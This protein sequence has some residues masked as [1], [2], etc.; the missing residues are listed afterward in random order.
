MISYRK[1]QEDFATFEHAM[2]NN[3]TSLAIEVLNTSK[4]INQ[5][6]INSDYTALVVASSLH[7]NIE[8]VKLILDHPEFD[9]GQKYQLC[10]SIK[11]VVNQY[12]VA[13]DSTLKETYRK[14]LLTLLS[15]KSF[16]SEL[17][18]KK[19]DLSLQY[20]GDVLRDVDD[21]VISLINYMAS[22]QSFSIRVKYHVSQ[23][24]EIRYKHNMAN[25]F[26]KLN[27][28]E[29]AMK[30]DYLAIIA[31]IKILNFARDERIFEFKRALP[32]GAPPQTFESVSYWIE[33]LQNIINYF[34]TGH[35][36]GMLYEITAKD[37][38]NAAMALGRAYLL[39]AI[40]ADKNDY[41]DYFNKAKQILD[42]HNIE[43]EANKRQFLAIFTSVTPIKDLSTNVNFV[44]SIDI[45]IAFAPA[46]QS[47]SKEAYMLLKWFYRST[48]HLSIGLVCHYLVEVCQLPSLTKKAVEDL[49]KHNVEVIAL[50][51]M[52]GL[53]LAADLA[54][55]TTLFEEIAETYKD[56]E[57]FRSVSACV[58]VL[59]AQYKLLMSIDQ[60]PSHEQRASI[61]EQ[62]IKTSDLLMTSYE[63]INSYVYTRT[64]V[65][66]F[67]EFNKSAPLPYQKI[68]LLKAL[69]NIYKITATY[70]DS[71]KYQEVNG[72]LLN[73]IW[74]RMVD[75]KLLET[76]IQLILNTLSESIENVYFNELG[77][78]ILKH[79]RNQIKLLNE[80]A[81]NSIA[82]YEI[83]QLYID[84]C[85]KFK[86]MLDT[87][88]FE[89]F[90]LTLANMEEIDVDKKF[91]IA[92]A[93][94][95]LGN[96][97]SEVFL[98]IKA[99]GKAI[100]L[101]EIDAVLDLC[102]IDLNDSDEMQLRYV[103]NI[104]QPLLISIL[105][106]NHPR[107]TSTVNSI[108]GWLIRN[109]QNF[110]SKAI[111]AEEFKK[112]EL[113]ANKANRNVI[114]E[115]LS[116]VMQN[117]YLPAF[118]N[119]AETLSVN[120][121]SECALFISA[122]LL[123][124]VTLHA[125]FHL[126]EYCI[127]FEALDN[128]AQKPF[129][130]ICTLANS[131]VDSELKQLASY[132][133][134]L[135]LDMKMTPALYANP[136]YEIDALI[137]GK[138]EVEND[139]L[140]PYIK[141]GMMQCLGVDEAYVRRQETHFEMHKGKRTKPTLAEMRAAVSEPV[142]E[143]SPVNFTSRINGI[144]KITDFFATPKPVEKTIVTIEDDGQE[145]QPLST[146]AV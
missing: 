52:Y 60:P 100:K 133:L 41:L 145:L 135:Y 70:K 77:E 104:M 136:E 102:D 73:Y 115:H 87:N 49:T 37:A 84:S 91:N 140:F 59:I 61:I 13:I 39:S 62:V 85:A 123:L 51:R 112:I 29:T 128:I 42:E 12:A 94:R 103:M 26:R 64:L 27:E 32:E 38:F 119:L 75:E 96:A 69:F 40:S 55:A 72:Q 83:M 146:F 93:Y 89:C 142:V 105:F 45:L 129:T 137:L 53:E 138:V 5:S 106:S 20:I 79:L 30:W 144:K 99:L 36:D 9:Y 125:E 28:L 120:H 34:E 127:E 81:N 65:A 19:L 6:K 92:A 113:V 97:I 131:R 43:V 132:Y 1:L 16:Y 31:A 126:S 15:H 121:E 47:S 130:I 63:L 143:V 35:V 10:F 22:Y 108:Y 4:I 82:E 25:R 33:V 80:S 44:D 116:L 86:V 88:D 21:S 114:G 54:I 109:K 23:S 110:I 17:I 56:T 101:G 124:E 48:R 68:I 50:T 141:N 134:Q 98:K 117:N 14:I 74:D 11:L 46:L 71:Q 122:R 78:I 2:A 8:I 111:A 3:F 24:H 118:I 57:K 67:I 66:L 76:N 139:K 90:S 58:M 7:P 107:D 18:D 95:K